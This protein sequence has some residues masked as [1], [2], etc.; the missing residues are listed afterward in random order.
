MFWFIALVL[1]AVA[2]YW[3]GWRIKN[4]KL[5][6]ISDQ[7][8]G[9]PAIP[10]L[11]NALQIAGPPEELTNVVARYLRDYGDFFRVW[12]GPDLNIFV[13]DPED[14]KTLLKSPKTSIKGP[15]YKYIKDYC[16]SGLLSGS[17]PSW[18]I[19]RKTVLP[20]YGKKALEAYDVVINEESSEVVNRLMSKAGGKTF[21]IYDDVVLGTTYTVCRTLMGLTK[22]QTINL[23]NMNVKF[24][25]DAHDL[26]LT[27][28][29]RMT[30]WYL[31][32]DP[33][34]WMTEHY[35][36]QKWFIKQITEIANTNV[37]HRLKVLESMDE[38]T[39]NEILNAEGDSTHNTELSVI[40]RLLLSN[41]ISTNDE[42]VKQWFT[43]FTASQEATAKITSYA[44]LM[45]AFHP[46]CQEKVYEEIKEVFGDNVRDVTE[47]DLKLM[48][49]LDMVFKE[50]IRLFPI[51]VM[52]QRTIAEDIKI[53]KGTLPA[54]SSL[55]VPI[56]HLHRDKRHWINPD[57]FDPERFTSENSRLRHPNC[58]I[59]FSL[60][61]MDCMG[62]Y[63]AIKLVKT[64][65]IKVLQKLRLSSTEKYEDLRL[66]M[67]VSV[68]SVNGYP[69]QV[70]P[71]S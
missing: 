41:K 39:I 68:A 14:I 51:G 70:Y 8:P 38:S 65:C 43:L 26:Y 15:Q 1:S 31:Q 48:P 42:L 21:D 20:N 19:C 28:F 56:F 40:D 30:Q 22:E 53:S 23:P 7:F 2:L 55:V 60:G 32:V 52:L 29:K 13:N 63:F 4:R 66:V 61:P 71:R 5:L 34:Y 54:G 46:K 24:L 16:G 49:Y 17:G 58:Y 37:K 36:K 67:A 69:V 33:I 27:V 50:V 11:G 12:V 62:R 35:Q 47:D 25:H 3:I 10:I 6:D 57:A 9:P 18:R 59:P 44:L 64:I 45:M